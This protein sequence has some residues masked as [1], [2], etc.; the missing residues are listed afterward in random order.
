VLADV[1]HVE[2]LIPREFGSDAVE[3]PGARE[4]LDALEAAQAP[5]AIVT[6]G[7]RPLMAGWLERM[8]LAE[9]RHCVTAED[10]Q[11]GKPDP[12]CYLLGKARLGLAAGDRT[13]VVEDAPAGIRAGKA[14]GCAVIGLTT[15]H[16]VEL[17]RVAGADW[18]VEDLRRV[19]FRGRDEQTGMLEMEI[20]PTLPA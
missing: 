8:Q 20:D 17:I 13:L 14:A 4:L 12:E 9:P 5:W 18:I 7:T 1:C 6:S 19:R 3:I 16:R 15:T 10:V 2:G 11:Q